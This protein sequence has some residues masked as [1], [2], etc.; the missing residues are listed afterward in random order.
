MKIL[1]VCLGNICRSPLAEGILRK[2]LEQ[3]GLADFVEVDSAGFEPFHT[4]DHPDPRSI[5]VAKKHGIDI[6]NLTAR[7]FQPEDFDTYDRIYVMDHNNYRDVI[8]CA[9]TKADQ[10]KVD[11][12]MNLTQPGL[13]QKVPDPWY[14]KIH[15]F[16]VTYSMLNK[17]I[18]VLQ[19]NIKLELK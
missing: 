16:E 9:R 18:D 4:G 13:N 17:A 19:K 7:L 1:F 5:A 8:M 2:K 15:D 11:F 10:E 3:E 12:V 14:G 6:S